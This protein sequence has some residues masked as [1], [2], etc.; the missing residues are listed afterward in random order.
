MSITLTEDQLKHMMESAVAA[1]VGALQITTQA[2]GTASTSTRSTVK[3]AERPEIDLGC[4]EVQWAF[5][6]DE[7]ESYKRRT[8]LIDDLKF[9]ELRASCTKE[10]RKTLFDFVGSST[11][12]T[13]NETKKRQFRENCSCAS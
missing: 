6:L 11:L 3:L 13:I 8:S 7:W 1:A 10:L 4:N 12:A 9:D 5:F 2:Q